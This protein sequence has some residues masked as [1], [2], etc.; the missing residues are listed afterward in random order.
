MEQKRELVFEWCRAAARFPVRGQSQETQLE[1][2]GEMRRAKIP[3]GWLV[4]WCPAGVTEGT[5]LTFVPDPQHEWDG[6]S[7]K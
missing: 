1:G 4:T 6:G 2:Y 5:G 3:G 7:L